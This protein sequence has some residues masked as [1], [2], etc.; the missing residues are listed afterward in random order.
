MTEEK[1]SGRI[2]EAYD[3]QD[4]IEEEKR[5]NV[6]KDTAN[7]FF[8]PSHMEFVHRLFREIGLERYNSILDLGSGDGRIVLIA[9]LFTKAEGI[10][11]DSELHKKAVRMRE[12]LC[13]SPE[14]AE[15]INADFMGHDISK[16]DV[17]YMYPDKPISR[18]LNEKLKKEL[19]G[20][21][22]LFSDSFVPEGLETRDIEIE[23]QKFCICR[24]S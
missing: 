8:V 13:I 2:I 12:K 3:K 11:S 20:T 1:E 16:H 4:S 23:W 19:R 17:I 18:E 10:E 15:L 14:K 7:G 5:G 24:N 6:L 22:I 9:S 21:L